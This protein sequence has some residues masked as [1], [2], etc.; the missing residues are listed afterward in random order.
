VFQK[1]RINKKQAKKGARVK[2]GDEEGESKNRKNGR[3]SAKG[4]QLF[5]GS[6]ERREKGSD[7]RG[8]RS[9]RAYSVIGS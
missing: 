9:G 5:G 1:C 6:V 3:K 4:T 7:R 8:V 2:N